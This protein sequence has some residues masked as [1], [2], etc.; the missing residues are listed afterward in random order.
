MISKIKD[1]VNKYRADIIL[2]IGVILI[3]LLSFA[4]GYVVAKQKEKELIN[5][6][7]TNDQSLVSDQDSS[8]E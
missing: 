6:E 1:F 2:I 8:P 3:S 7:V 4:V 5:F